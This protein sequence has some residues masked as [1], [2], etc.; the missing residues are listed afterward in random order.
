MQR[1]IVLD[2]NAILRYLINDIP[3]QADQVSQILM[4]REVLVLPEVIAEV[5]YTMAKYYNYDKTSLCQKILIFLQDAECD[6]EILIHAIN[7]FSE[8]KFDFVDCILLEYDK[9]P[10][11][12]IFT[13]DKKLKKQLN[14]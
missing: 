9:L 3:D 14:K 10:E 13:F 8:D 12:E 5:I 6:S 7:T 1:T 2:A 11:Y 4:N